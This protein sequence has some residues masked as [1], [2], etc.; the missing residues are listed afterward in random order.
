MAIKLCLRRIL[1]VMN[2][3]LQTNTWQVVSLHISRT[4][5]LILTRVQLLLLS[6]KFLQSSSS[7]GGRLVRAPS[8]LRRT[9]IN[10]NCRY[11]S[12]KVSRQLL[13]PPYR[14]ETAHV[15][16]RTVAPSLLHGK[17]VTSFWRYKRCSRCDIFAGP[18][19]V[20]NT[21]VSGRCCVLRGPSR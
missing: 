15:H 12:I 14:F 5:N 10:L 17:L 9:W 16:T 13:T 7:S 4:R 19:H 2:T 3:I 8:T 20:C 18:H 11:R 6:H 1:E 21:N